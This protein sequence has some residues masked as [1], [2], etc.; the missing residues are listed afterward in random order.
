[1]QKYDPEYYLACV[2]QETLIEILGDWDGV[3]PLFLNYLRQEQKERMDYYSYCYEWGKVMGAPQEEPVTMDS[4]PK[5]PERSAHTECLD[6]VAK[7]QGGQL[8]RLWRRY[9]VALWKRRVYEGAYM[10]SLGME[11]GGKQERA[12]TL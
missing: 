12:G 10:T 2:T 3:G 4:F 8:R 11:D 1:M 7:K 6:E 9:Q 5:L